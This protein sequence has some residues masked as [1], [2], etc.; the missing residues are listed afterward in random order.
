MSVGW[1]TPRYRRA[2][3]TTT[4]TTPIAHFA[5]ERGRP[6]TM[7][8][9]IAP[10]AETARPAIG[11]EGIEYPCHPVRIGIPSGRGRAMIDEALYATISVTMI[12]PRNTN[13]WRQRRNTISARITLQRI[14]RIVQLDVSPLTTSITRVSPGV[15]RSVTHCCRV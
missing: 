15:R 14:T 8:A 12:A 1:S 13:R 3:P 9:Y 5:I 6:A 10:T 11:L 2:N 4:R 7:S